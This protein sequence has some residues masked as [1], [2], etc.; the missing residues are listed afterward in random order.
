MEE[1]ELMQLKKKTLWMSVLFFVVM[2]GMAAAQTV[3]AP[4]LLVSYP[5][6]I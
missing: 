1:E 5:E 4:R 2:A 6:L 3:T